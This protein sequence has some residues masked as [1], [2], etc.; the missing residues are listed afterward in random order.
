M[1]CLAH[2]LSILAEELVKEGMRFLYSV[3]G[4]EARFAT[5]LCN[6]QIQ[7][8]NQS[9]SFFF[10]L[11]TSQRPHTFPRILWIFISQSKLHGHCK[12]RKLA[13]YN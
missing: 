2:L 10:V 4:H 11:C 5:H 13:F 8:I 6:S 12:E 3:S 1:L 7:S 9:W